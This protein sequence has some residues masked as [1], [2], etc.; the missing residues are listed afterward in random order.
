[1]RILAGNFGGVFS[2]FRLRRVEFREHNSLIPREIHRREVMRFRKTNP[3][4]PGQFG[5]VLN[6]IHPIHNTLLTLYYIYDG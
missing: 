4:S 6:Y 1:M 3:P 5:G 2:P